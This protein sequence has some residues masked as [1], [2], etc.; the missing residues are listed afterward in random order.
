[1][2]MSISTTSGSGG[3][4]LEA[5]PFGAV[6]G[7]AD[8]GDVVLGVQQHLEAGAHQLLVVGV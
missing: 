7:L 4:G 2:R 1:M 3:P 6:G 8:D 5:T